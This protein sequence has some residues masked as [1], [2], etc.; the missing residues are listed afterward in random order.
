MARVIDRVIDF[1]R[2]LDYIPPVQRQ[3]IVNRLDQPP[4]R[5]ELDR[6]LAQ[7]YPSR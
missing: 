5:E 1:V 4:T 7:V 3:V 2:A 6:A